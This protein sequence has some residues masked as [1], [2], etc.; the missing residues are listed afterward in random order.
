M[1]GSLPDADLEALTW[2]VQADKHVWWTYHSMN[3]IPLALTLLTILLVI[4]LVEEIR[5]GFCQQFPLGEMPKAV[6]IGINVLIYLYAI[7][8]IGLN[9][10]DHT[11][12]LIM[13]WLFSLAMLLNALG[14]LGIML[15]RR[16]YFPG[17]Y[18]AVFLLLA[19]FNVLRLLLI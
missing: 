7:I 9:L 1:P 5:T 18:S 17:G 12:A 16:K 8:M 4:H 6:F 2:K 13:A 15:V 11:A 19:R 3:S 10:L 14:H